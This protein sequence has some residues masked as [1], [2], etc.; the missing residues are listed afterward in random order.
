MN[1]T[2]LERLRNLAGTGPAPE[3]VADNSHRNMYQIR[4][5]LMESS[6]HQIKESYVVTMPIDDPETIGPKLYDMFGGMA[7]D[8]GWDDE[9]NFEAYFDDKEDAKACARKLRNYRHSTKNE[10]PKI[11]KE[12][13]NEKEK[14]DY[15]DIDGD[16]DEKESMKKA[17][18]DKEEKVD[19]K[20]SPD[21]KTEADMMREWANSIY[22]QYDDREHYHEQPPGETVDLSLRRYLNADPMKVKIEED[23]E[24]KDMLKEYKDYKDGK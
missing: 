19:E 14:P 11:T 23:I 2:E 13:L 22:K 21:P 5:T 15:A 7:D 16:G 9:G 18:K 1:K 6:K 20:V 4:D 10:M 8:I 3:K 17:A 24:E 12:G